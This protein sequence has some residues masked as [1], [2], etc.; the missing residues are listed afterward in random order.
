MARPR[1]RPPLT[2]GVLSFEEPTLTFPA[3]VVLD[4]SFIVDALI[5]S[6]PL[7]AQCRT[8]L[9]AL[10]GAESA[11]VFNRLLEIEL[12]EA[13][14]QLAL[15][16][17]FQRHWRR[18]R[19]DGRVRRRATRLMADVLWAWDEIKAV[20]PS[21]CIELEEVMSEVP[22]LMGRYG[23]ASYDAVHAASA[24]RAGVAEFVTLDV[25]FAA[26]PATFLTLYA[27]EARVARCRE[28]RGARAA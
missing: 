23:L 8:F 18:H 9:V 21:R 13:A 27:N 15:K 19:R 26:V 28:L 16:E 7:H 17:R 25:G 3:H 5:S 2:R 20:M 24:L 4:T 12:A 10:A 14:F 22:R 6:Q 11:I 1:G